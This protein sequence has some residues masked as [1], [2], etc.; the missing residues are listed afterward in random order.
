MT[1][2]ITDT[3]HDEGVDAHEVGTLEHLDPHTL[4]VDTNCATRPT[5]TPISSPA[6]QSTAC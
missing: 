4:V 6:S 3:Q 2:T 5:S 1:E